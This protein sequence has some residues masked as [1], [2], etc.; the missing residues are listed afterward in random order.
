VYSSL[1]IYGTG[2][3]GVGGSDFENKISTPCETHHNKHSIIFLGK[4][5]LKG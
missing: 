5:S 2:E 1:N 4:Y 3:L